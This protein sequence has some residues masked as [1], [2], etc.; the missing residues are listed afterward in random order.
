M[1]WLE[2]LFRIFLRYIVPQAMAYFAAP[3]AMSLIYQQMIE[4]PEFILL[5]GV[6]V[7]AIEAWWIS[8]KAKGGAT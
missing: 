2:P 6:L 8:A 3:E 4:S 5:L 1:T 7:A